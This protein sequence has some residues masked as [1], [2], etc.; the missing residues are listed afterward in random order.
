MLLGLAAH[1]SGW[2]DKHNRDLN[3]PFGVTH[4]GGPDVAYNS[5]AD[6]VAYWEHRYGPVVRGA[7]SAQ[8]FVQRLYEAK[9]NI[10][11]GTWRG[12]D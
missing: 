8:D 12:R 3:D 6:T 1:E 2:L 10:A 4:G 5:I 9:Y 11:T 7:T